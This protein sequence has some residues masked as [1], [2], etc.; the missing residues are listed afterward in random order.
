M[1]GEDLEAEIHPLKNDG[2][3]WRGGPGARAGK[4]GGPRSPAPQ[5]RLSR[6]R[7][8]AFFLSLF[9]CLLVVF[10]V[11]F[12][13]PCPDRPAPQGAW[14]VSYDSAGTPRPGSSVRE[15]RPGAPG[16]AGAGAGAGRARKGRG[17]RATPK[18]RAAAEHPG[19]N[20]RRGSRRGPGRLRW[21]GRGKAGAPP[22]S[23]KPAG[24]PA[25]LKSCPGGVS[26]APCRWVWGRGPWGVCWA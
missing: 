17:L 26:P 5:P 25:L 10:V 4:G 20:R 15:A 1:G 7:T 22:P 6:C 16:G 13:V 21:G 19:P 9:A 18:K 2:G 24:V 23:T 3:K 8:A 12:A 11:S 14:S